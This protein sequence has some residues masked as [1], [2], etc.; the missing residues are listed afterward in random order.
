MME[1]HA[2]ARTQVHMRGKGLLRSEGTLHPETHV[3][4]VER[5]I[6]VTADW[7]KVM[8]ADASDRVISV[9]EHMTLEDAITDDA[10]ITHLDST[11]DLLSHLEQIHQ[12]NASGRTSQ[13]VGINIEFDASSKARRDK[14]PILC[15]IGLYCVDSK[16]R[17]VM[18]SVD[19]TLFGMMAPSDATRVT[20]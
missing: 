20:A 17:V 15:P 9:T 16:S 5:G 6:V 18:I 2:G 11:E 19:M 3:D 13:V 12:C 10:V 1:V 7:D 14:R 8:H 4:T